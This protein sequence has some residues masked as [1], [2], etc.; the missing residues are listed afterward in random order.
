MSGTADRLRRTPH[1]SRES[2]P[3]VVAAHGAGLVEATPARPVQHHV[4]RGLDAHDQPVDQ[5]TD[6]GDGERDQA[7]V[8][9]Q[10]RHQ[11]P[12]LSALSGSWERTTAK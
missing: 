4:W 8:G 6:L 5:P 3:S 7:V 2:A 1:S 12:P 9:G 10:L 11:S